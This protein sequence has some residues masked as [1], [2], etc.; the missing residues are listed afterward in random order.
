MHVYLSFCFNI[1]TW[2]CCNHPKFIYYTINSK[3]IP[4]IRLN[5]GNSAVL[6]CVL[7]SL[8]SQWNPWAT[9]MEV[10]IIRKIN[11]VGVTV[12]YTVYYA[13]LLLEVVQK[14]FPRLLPIVLLIFPVILALCSNTNIHM[15][16][17]LYEYLLGYFQCMPWFM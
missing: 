7:K 9:G 14:Y 6:I 17:L 10:P 11:T 12:C 4:N 3:W 5:Y 8:Q 13:L 1:C 2:F 15:K 16:T